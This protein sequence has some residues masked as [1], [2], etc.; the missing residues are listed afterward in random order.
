VTGA[1]WVYVE[2]GPDGDVAPAALELLTKARSLAAGV[3]AVALGPG[4]S[5][6]AEILGA[7][8]ASTV[9]ASD[10]AV[11]SDHPGEPAAYSLGL[12]AREHEPDLILFGPSYDSRDVAGRVQAMLG[13]ALV[14]NVDDVLD[15]DHLRLTTALSLWPGRPGNLRGG[16]AGAKSVDV[17]LTG[18]APR[19]VLARTGAFEALP[20][21]GS[22]NVVAVDVEVPA[23]RMRTRLRERH[24]EAGEGPRLDEA[25]VVIAGGRGLGEPEGFALLDELAEAIGDAA[26]G[27]TRPV[28][29]AG[30]VPFRM[31][32]GQTGK[33]V[34]PDVYIAVGISGAAQHVVGM[35]ESRRIVA[36]N[37][38]P[39]APIFE[40][41][42]LR[43]VGDALTVV[44]A[45][46]AELEAARVGG[47]G[48][49]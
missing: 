10:D 6:A 32:I 43:I 18:P 44:P 42:D 31:Q 34:K 17:E 19:L 2:V 1:I 24:E 47:A 5:A 27:A 13:S 40:H 21:G 9:F 22:A 25:R 12:L 28:V 8:G 15:R 36:I 20:S 48:A 11:Y 26:V 49:R 7:Y 46:I 16:I 14:A 33:T 4:A 45:L 41:A 23:T 35:K 37:S 3:A 38:D 39:G 30:W 29:D